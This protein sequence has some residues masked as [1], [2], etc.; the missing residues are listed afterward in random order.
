MCALAE[1]S[2]ST[3]KVYAYSAYGETA[4]LGPDGG[5]ALRYT[6]REDDGNGLFYYRAR[7]YDPVLKRFVSEDPIALEAGP[8]FY[9]YVDGDPV[10]VIDPEG[11]FGTTVGALQRGVTLNQAVEM[12]APGVAATQVGAG[13]VG[14]GVVAANAPGAAVAAGAAI[15]APGAAIAAASSPQGRAVIAAGL[16]GLAQYTPGLAQRLPSLSSSAPASQAANLNAAAQAA[17][18]AAQGARNLPRINRPGVSR[19]FVWGGGAWGAGQIDPCW[20]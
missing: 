6:G 7:Y 15:Q 4:V 3:E 1:R 20:P 9:T 17:A 14:A 5:N 13:I 12:G 16:Q 10:S 8:N 19:A 11:Y 2:V 18:R